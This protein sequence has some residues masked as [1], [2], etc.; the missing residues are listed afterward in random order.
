MIYSNVLKNILKEKFTYEE[1]SDSFINITSKYLPIESDFIK[2]WETT[3][4]K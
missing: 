2:F 4:T 1:S 3:I